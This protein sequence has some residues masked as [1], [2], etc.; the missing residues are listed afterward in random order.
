[1]ISVT[2][3]AGGV[4]R[5][6]LLPGRYEIESVLCD[7][8]TYDGPR[9]AVTI[10]EGQTHR[11]AL[12]LTPNVRGVVRDPAGLPVAGARVRIVGAGREEVISDEQGRFAI[13]WDRRFQFRD[14]LTFC[15][16][17]QHELRNLA[18][19][20]TIGRG[21]TWLDVKLQAYPVLAGRLTDSNGQGLAHASAYVTL[22]VPNW[23]DTPLSEEVTETGADGRFEI[24]AVPAAGQCTLHVDAEAHG[25]KDTVVPVKT[26]DGLSFDV[27]T[28]MLLPANLSISG[29]VLDSRGHPVARAMIY[30]WGEGQPIK[31]NTETDPEGRFTLGRVCAGQ[32]NLRIDVDLGDGKH[33]QV[34]TLANAG[35]TGLEITSRDP[36]SRVSQER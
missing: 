17:A 32:V 4:A 15:L 18:T 35:A 26:A 21:A 20:M 22:R 3:D 24:R 1:V 16:L 27:G 19:A 9:Q 33:V 8:Y 25:S 30:G 11:I 5:I 14:A 29:R 23:G 12:L 28:L 10:E 36:Y 6:R 31:L 34:R 7:S 2:S 13:A